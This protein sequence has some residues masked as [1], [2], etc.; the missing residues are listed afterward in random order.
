MKT[1]NVIWT[2]QHCVSVE[3]ESE[4]EAIEKVNSGEGSDDKIEMSGG[5]D[6]H[7]I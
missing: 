7:E 5:F 3:A 4:E 6:A 1:Y 2:E